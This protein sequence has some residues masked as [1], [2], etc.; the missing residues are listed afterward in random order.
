VAV[1]EGGRNQ[2]GHYLQ[3]SLN[4]HTK[5]YTADGSQ[6]SARD[7][8]YV[9]RSHSIEAVLAQIQAA[10]E[11]LARAARLLSFAERAARGFYV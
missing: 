5:F 10:R 11:S 4:A 1:A 2:A 9:E 6:L 3:H 7:L 8:Q